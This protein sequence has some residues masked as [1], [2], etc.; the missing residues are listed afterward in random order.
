MVYGILTILLIAAGVLG[1]L[2]LSLDLPATVGYIAAG[3]AIAVWVIY[4]IVVFVRNDRERK[5]SAK[6]CF[7]EIALVAVV[8]TLTTFICKYDYQ[9]MFFTM[10]PCFMSARFV[11]A[12][13]AR[14]IEKRRQNKQQSY[15]GQRHGQGYNGNGGYHRNQGY[16]NYHGHSGHGRHKPSITI[17]F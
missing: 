14:I 12:F 5:D 3:V 17:R 1:A 4:Y 11:V 15:N 13:I 8:V 2:C 7:I 9:C 6:L 10:A 16:N